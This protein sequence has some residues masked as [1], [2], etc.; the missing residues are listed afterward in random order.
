MGH[1]ANP[2]SFRL[3]NIY[4]WNSLWFANKKNFKKVLLEDV[5][6]REY[7][8]KKLK[9][10]G[11][12]G[13]KIE[14]SINKIKIIPQ[15]TRPGVVIGRGGAGLEELKKELSKMVSIPEPEKNLEIS[16]EEVKNP[17]ISAVFVA[18]RIVE[19]LERRVPHRY[20]IRK[21]MERAMSSGAEGIKVALSGRIAGAEIARAEKYSEGKVPLQTL[22]AKIDYADV[23]AL[24]RSGYVGVKVWIYQGEKDAS[25]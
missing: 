11:I 1:K 25:A 13:V 19:Q 10:A 2:I 18:Q 9:L 24:T 4:T 5:S 8:M 6:L 20:V 16:P 17:D 23:P 7:L 15:V 14:R 12:I 21:A 22:R 3:G